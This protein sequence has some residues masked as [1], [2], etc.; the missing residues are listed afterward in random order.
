MKIVVLSGGSGND[1]LIKGLNAYAVNGGFELHVIVNAYDN[2]KSTGVC[3]AVTDTL[4]VSDIRKN[5]I[6]M[7]EALHGGQADENILAFYDSRFD[8]T[9]R[10][11]EEEISALLRAWGMEQYVP[12]AARFFANPK[13]HNFAYRDFSVSNIVYAQMYREIGYEATNRHFC[14]ELLGIPDFVVLNSF[15]NVYIKA[16]TKSGYVIEDEGKTVFWNNA[17]DKIVKTLYDVRSHSG[18]NSRAVDLVRGA[19]LLIISTGTFWSSIQPTVEYLDFYKHINDSPAKKIWVLNN[20]EDGDSFG[21]T[22]L[23]FVRHMEETGLSLR[24]FTILVNA[25]A[26]PSLRLTG[27]AHRFA[28]AKMGNRKGKHDGFLY[29]KAILR[30]YYGIESAAA[31]DRILLDFDDTVWARGNSEAEERVSRENVLLINEKLAEKAVIVS[32]NSYASIRAKLASV[33][34]EHLEGFRVDVWADANSTLFRAE[35]RA[36]FLEELAVDAA[37]GEQVQR[38]AAEFGMPVETVGARPVCYKIK[39]LAPLERRLFAALVRETCPPC[40]CAKCTGNTTVDVVSAG[41]NK[42]AVFEHCGYAGLTTLYIGDEAVSGN[43]EAISRRCT[44]SVC[45]GSAAETNCILKLL[46]E[47]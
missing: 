36:E 13:A 28:C 42:N 46:T 47:E 11:E 33:Y 2:G 41:N 26:R 29:A 4:G 6:R 38:L 27:E 35:G 16:Q 1:A 32:G 23:E 44:H 34:G 10:K 24:D 20:E 45:V 30:L 7:Y 12:Y 14:E 25:D 37:A 18:L 5:H 43:D 19:D 31:Y 40:V 8:F 15:D 17:A 22:S 21:V 39:P 9:A 3:R